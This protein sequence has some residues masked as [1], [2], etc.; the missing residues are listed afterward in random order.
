V[1]VPLV[2]LLDRLYALDLGADTVSQ[3]VGTIQRVDGWCR[4]RGWTVDDVPGVVL[5]RFAEALPMSYSSRKL[6]RSALQAY[7]QVAGRDD[8]PTGA[9]K[10]PKKPRMTSRALAPDDAARLAKTAYQWDEGPEGLAV[11]LGLY[12]GLRRAEIARLRWD[13]FRAD[14]WCRVL[15]KWGV[16]ADLPVHPV[17]EERLAW[18]KGRRDDDSDPRDP[19]TKPGRAYLF[20][21]HPSREHTLG[22]RRIRSEQ[23]VGATTVW[24]WVRRVGDVAGVAVTTHQLRHTAL[25]E[26]LDRTRDLRA[27]QML[28]RHADPATTAGYTR[29]TNQRLTEAA[30]SINYDL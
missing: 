27:V 7:W 25:T 21:G 3:Y 30:M 17:I 29:V 26:A 13:N 1:R 8:P 15:G 9:I 16:V 14:G 12:M 4:E 11:L 18:W 10:V 2:E 28:A 6:L 24:T 20:G 5:A 19:Q 23:P 22:G